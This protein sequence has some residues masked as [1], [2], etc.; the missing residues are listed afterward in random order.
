MRISKILGFRRVIA[1]FILKTCST[2]RES[3]GWGETTYFPPHPVS[4]I[5]L[6]SS[7]FPLTISFMKSACSPPQQ[8]S[9]RHRY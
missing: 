6:H 5:A 3:P 8:I 1:K 4:C 9:F 7:L 2:S